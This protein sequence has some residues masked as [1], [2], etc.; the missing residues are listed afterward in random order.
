MELNP[1][2]KLNGIDT[3]AL[4]QVMEEVSKYPAK[5]KVKFQVLTSWKGTTRTET[6]VESYKIGGQKIKRNFKIAIDE[7]EE[8]LGE[9]TAAN[10][11]EVLMAALNACVMNTYVIASA[12][13]GIKL[14]SVE[15]ETEGE[16]DLRGFLGI[17]KSIK[18]GY[19]EI[20][21]KVHIKGDG[22][23]EQFEEVHRTV[24]ATSPNYWNISNQ[25]RVCSD[26]IIE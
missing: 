13:K 22:T 20:R 10:P 9:N 18:P 14:E 1:K 17:D 15:I 11:Q 23:K 6:R 5:G 2:V 21:Y 7:P 4:K 12:M 26:I 25:I 16:L 19:D 3:D 8:L 24:M